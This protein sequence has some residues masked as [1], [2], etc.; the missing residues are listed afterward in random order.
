ML[1]TKQVTITR[2]NAPSVDGRDDG[3]SFLITEM[4]AFQA[5]KWATRA[6]LALI[7]RLTREISEEVAEQIAVNPGMLPLERVGLLLGSIQFPETQALMDEIFEACVQILPDPQRPL[8]RA[9][10]LGGSQDIFEVATLS[11][12]RSEA[13]SLHSNFTLAAGILNLISAVSTM[14]PFESISTSPQPAGQSSAPGRPP[15][16]SSS[17]ST[18]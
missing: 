10:N 5:E 8:P 9:I 6:T 11:Y 7:P 12:L 15:S 4:P 17:P 2:D 1:K 18:H 16:T 3:K 14:S 13:L